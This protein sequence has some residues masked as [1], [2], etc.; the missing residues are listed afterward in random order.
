MLRFAAALGVVMCVCVWTTGCAGDDEGEPG[1]ARDVGAGPDGGAADSEDS[2]GG[3]GSDATLDGG[4]ERPDVAV[5]GG[6]GS[7]DAAVDSGVER[8][9]GADLGPEGPPT[10]VG[11]APEAAGEVLPFGGFYRQLMDDM[12]HFHYHAGDWT[13]DFGDAAYYGPA[14]LVDMGIEYGR[15]DYMS[16]ALDAHARN[17][18][19]LDRAAG[20][21]PYFIDQLQEV[22]MAAFGAI[23][24]L[25]ALGLDEGL[26]SIEG[27]LDSLRLTVDTLGP[28]LDI[29]MDSYA[30]YTYG[31]TSVTGLVV[32]L[33][34]RYA[35]FLDTPRAAE[36][37]EYGL[38]VLEAIDV[39]AWDGTRYL[40]APDNERL[41]LYPNVTMLMANA[42]AFQLTGEAVYRERALAVYDAIQPLKD[43]D[44]GGYRSP[45]SAETM[46][47]QTDDYLTLSSQN[48]TLSSL[49]LLYEITGEPGYRDEFAEVVA[50]VQSYLYSEGRVLPHW[51]DG[52]L[53]LPHD[54]E[55]FCS[56]CNLQ[57]LYMAR[58]GE[59]KLWGAVR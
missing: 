20:D 30:L 32:L 1:D 33:N 18:G 45:Y 57:L 58:Y 17:L 35:Q 41:Y 54:P 44:K 37:L 12:P 28:Y 38:E 26:T 59:Q 6:A 42:T 9:A 19:V 47:A 8:D 25:A 15:D 7:A 24:V 31:P 5:D 16:W 4:A 13:E 51:M 43:L 56:G 2:G 50:F 34:L 52:R 49:A 46:G 53:A 23:E 39:A 48:Y 40:F 29:E 36:R 27:V 55:Y 22:P 10:P 11:A 3:E 14:Y 21:L